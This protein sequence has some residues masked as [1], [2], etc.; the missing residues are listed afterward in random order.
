MKHPPMNIRVKGGQVLSGEI[1]PSG[2]KNAAVALLP[3]SILFDRPLVLKNV[4]EITDTNRLNNILTKLGSKITWDK[5]Q[6]TLTLN[7]VKLSFEKIDR[8]DLGNM[9]GT[10]LFWGPMLGRFKKVNFE[11]LPGGCTLGLRL[12]DAH[13]NAF[14]DLGVAVIE[15]DRGVKM[16]ASRAKAGEVW[17][18]EMSPTATENTLML[19]VTLK[20]KTKIF[21]AASEPNIQDL[22]HFL[23]KCGSKITGVGSNILQIEGGRPLSPIPHPI[24]TD[25]Y[26]IATFLAFGAATGGKIKVHHAIPEHFR[27]IDN[28]FSEF[29]LKIEYSNGTAILKDKQEIK[30]NQ[31]GAHPLTV[32]AQPWPAL[33]VDILPLFIPLALAAR[34]GQVLFHNWM[35]EAGLF[36]TSELQK[37]GA[38]IIMCDPHRVIVTAGN[39]LRGATLEAPYIIRAVVSM[40]LAAMIAEGD[41]LILNADTLYRG[42]PHFSENLKKLGA[43]IEEVN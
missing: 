38:N 40:V 18:S 3:T 37:L 43:I 35:Y 17:L 30:I 14:K 29:G 21:N 7:N 34:S 9:R 20:G 13:Y 22:C 19:A 11:E 31:D 41:S 12:P 23:N 4:P 33:P 28:Q 36:W 39:K 32:R 8:E 1:Y 10:S 6:K 25:H 15:T 42:H 2:S 27:M 16:D 26:E 24:I 5:T